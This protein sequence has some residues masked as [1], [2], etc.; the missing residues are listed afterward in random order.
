MIDAAVTISDD[1]LLRDAQSLLRTHRFAAAVQ[2]WESLEITGHAL[3]VNPTLNQQVWFAIVCQRCALLTGDTDLTRKVEAFVDS[4]P[5]KLE[6]DEQGLLRHDFPIASARV[7]IHGQVKRFAHRLRS[8]ASSVAPRHFPRGEIA[9]GYHAFLLYSL[10][11]L[12]RYTGERHASW[13]LLAPTIRRAVEYVDAH[14]PYGRGESGFR[15]GY[16]PVG[17]EMSFALR[18]FSRMLPTPRISAT[19]WE[20]AQVATYFDWNAGLMIRSSVDPDTLAARFYEWCR[21]QTA[22]G[23]GES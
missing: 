11:L 3:G 8:R 5:T 18:A 14:F 19:D 20:D 23:Q 2:A 16:N 22:L 15:W 1:A 9:V 21:G 4:L 13:A 12:Y 6:I 10:A 17:F 7:A